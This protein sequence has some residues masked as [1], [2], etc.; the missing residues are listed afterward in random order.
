MWKKQ[1]D[2]TVQQPTSVQLVVNALGV[3]TAIPAVHE[4]KSSFVNVLLYV[5]FLCSLYSPPLH[6][7]YIISKNQDA[8]EESVFFY[9]VNYSIAQLFGQ[10]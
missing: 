5:A 7:P 1:E 6:T 3:M 2:K 9:A 4:L 10:K 8:Y